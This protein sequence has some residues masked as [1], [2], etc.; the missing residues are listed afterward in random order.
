MYP[1]THFL[2]AWLIGLL[3]VK[4]GNF[5]PLQALYTGLVGMLIDIDHFICFVLRKKDFSLKD[6]WNAAVKHKLEE[7]TFIHHLPGFLI[8][9]LV[10]VGLFFVNKIYFW[11]LLIGYYSH[12]ILDYFNLREWMGIR[13]SIKFKEEGFIFRIPLV[14]IIF[15]IILVVFVLFI[16]L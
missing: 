7:R 5:T 6:A 8:I 12:M 14:E 1:L 3:M 15:D 2:V 10:L 9:S 13:K 11:I 16:L 4:N